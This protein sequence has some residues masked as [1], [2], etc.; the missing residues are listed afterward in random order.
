MPFVFVQP[1]CH[2]STARQV[3]AVLVVLNQEQPVQDFHLVFFRLLLLEPG[4]RVLPASWS[5][6]Q[7]ARIGRRLV[8]RVKMRQSWIMRHCPDQDVSPVVKFLRGREIG[9]AAHH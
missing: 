1:S 3:D 9:R 4:S 2:I 7:I 8:L 5:L 6:E